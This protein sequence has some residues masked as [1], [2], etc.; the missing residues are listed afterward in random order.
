MKRKKEPVNSCETAAAKETS[1]DPRGESRRGFLKGSVSIVAGAAAQFLPSQVAA[2]QNAAGLA[3]RLRSANANGRPI[4][5]KDGIVLS[6][7]PK[8]GDFEKADVLIQGKKIVS[9]GPSLAAPAQAVVVNADRM[10]VMP[11][12]VDTHHHQYMAATRSIVADSLILSGTTRGPKTNFSSVILQTL[13]PAYTPTTFIFPNS[14][15]RSAK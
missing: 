8:V 15:R 14:R 4:L 7:D 10:I 9:I 13:T 5:L 2:Q 6:M 11:G 3:E 1:G 12:F